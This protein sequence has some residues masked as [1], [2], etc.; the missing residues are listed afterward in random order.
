M[1]REGGDGGELSWKKNMEVRTP[2]R[3]DHVRKEE[4]EGEVLPV[5]VV[6]LVRLRKHST[7]S[8]V[9]Y[10]GTATLTVRLEIVPILLVPLH[11]LKTV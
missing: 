1:P 8:A 3:R 2:R 4:R 5:E 10:I 9:P 7:T 6:E 11:I